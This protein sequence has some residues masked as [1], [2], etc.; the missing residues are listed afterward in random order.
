MAKRRKKNM[1]MMSMAMMR[2]TTTSL[3]GFLFRNLKGQRLWVVIA[4]ILTLVQVGSDLLHPFP[5]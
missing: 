1:M 2:T 3:A 4:A 5:F